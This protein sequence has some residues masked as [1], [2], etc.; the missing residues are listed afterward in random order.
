MRTADQARA[1]RDALLQRINSLRTELKE[2]NY[3][4]YT[5]DAPVI[6]DAEYDRL[7]RQL[8]TLEAELGEPVPQDS[9]TQVIGAIPS[10]T[11]TARE[12]GEP[13]LSLANAFNEEEVEAFIHRISEGLDEDK[14]SFI[15]EPKIDG[16]A[17]NLRY[18]QGGILKVAATRGDGSTG[19]DVTDNIRTIS[20]IPWH[21]IRNDIPVPDVLEVRGEVYMSKASFAEL[22]ER[23][24]A[25]GSSPFA[26]PRNAAAGSLRQLD[27]CVTAKRGLRFFAYGIGLGGHELAANQSGLMQR[28]REFGFRVQETA[29]ANDA[30]TLLQR[31]QLLLEQR[32]GMPY[33]IDGVVYKL[34]DFSLQARLG[35]VARSPRWAIAH[36][37]PAEEATT[38]AKDII[39][40]IGRTGVIT[41]VADMQP[42]AVGGVMV[43]RATLHNIEEMARKQVYAGATVVVRRA[44]DVIPEVVRTVDVDVAAAMPEPPTVCP[45]CGAAVYQ[46]EGE[47]AIRCG[48]GLSCPAQLKERLRHFVS[49]SAM[50][51]E[52][53]GEKLIAKLVDE[54]LLTSI[55]DIYELEYSLLLGWPGMG[56][57]KVANLQA[58]LEKSRKC[59]LSRF[60]YALGIRH[61]GQA[62]AAALAMHFENLP[63]VIEA[64]E[65]SLVA[66]PDIGPE[67]AASISS[68]FAELHNRDVINRLLGAGVTPQA[69]NLQ[70]S[71]HPLAGKTVVLTGSFK[72]IQRRQAQERLRALGAKPA[73]SV[74]GNTDVVVAGE[75][76]GSKLG[77]A[78]ELGI[79]VA[80]EAQLLIWLGRS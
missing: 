9:P 33:E 77:K 3:R 50:D 67:V 44:G 34:D 30:R 62:T 19:E 69:V 12:H 72:H 73:G 24:D 41:P 47:V 76:A 80:D 21:L 38:K 43:S 28:L 2:H 65:D 11:F 15:I 78:H 6:P 79:K 5:L 39:W 1:N 71:E 55:A 27:A 16:L 40:Q 36:K 32:S 68:F 59:L 49:R 31:Y 61:V 64:D 74:S 23:Q 58:A 8:E 10:Q 35:A 57:K 37:F 51:I 20:D 29:I 26:N 45:A 22:N 46:I 18:E 52:G 56:E 66:V 53:M 75:K 7:L 4:Y 70:Q 25:E 17:V 54:G 48:G 60:L 14:L 13:L 42:V 63:A